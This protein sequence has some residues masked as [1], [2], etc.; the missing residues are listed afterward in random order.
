MHT[1]SKSLNLAE[2]IKPYVHQNQKILLAF[3]GGIDSTVLLHLLVALKHPYNLQLR[4]IYVHH[5]L[6]PHANNWAKHVQQICREFQIPC[7]IEHIMV[8]GTRN[9]EA[10]AR[11][12]RY[13]AI[14]AHLRKD[15]VVMTAQHL[16]DQCETF[17]L[18][19]K[20]G[21]GPTGL[22]AMP[23][24]ISF[25][26]SQFI[27]PFLS[28]PRKKIEAYAHAHNLQWVEDESNDDCRYDRNFLRLSVIPILMQRWPHFN[29]MVARSAALCAEET[30]LLNELIAEEMTSCL[31]PNKT[32]RLSPLHA[33][34]FLKRNA[35]L[36]AWLKLHRVTM[37]SRQQLDLLWDTVACAKVD[38]NPQFKLGQHTVRRFQNALHV[39]TPHASLSQC[40]LPWDLTAPLVLPN[41]I[42]FLKCLPKGSLRKPQSDETVTIR[43][44]GHGNVTIVGRSRSRSLKKLWQECGIPPWQRDQIPLLYYNELLITAVGVFITHEGQGHE[45]DITLEQ[46]NR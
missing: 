39:I 6:S 40:V 38:A 12:A 29:E 11:H 8:D 43:F 9:V 1:Q 36:R 21:S 17:L 14:A 41:M 13:E 22:A 18:A 30:E 5:G 16:D 20:R 33:M 3:S 44:R 26:S 25:Y 32:L 4:A 10:Q 35:I 15:E 24:V 37:P 34:S 19:L 45:L 23:T 31:A 7:H 2:K 28:I 42:G 46:E 27:R